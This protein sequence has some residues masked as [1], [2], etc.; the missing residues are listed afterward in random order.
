M[1]STAGPRPRASPRGWGLPQPPDWAGMRLPPT[2]RAALSAMDGGAEAV[3]LG[4]IA[5]QRTQSWRLRSMPA[6]AADSGSRVSEASTQATASPAAVMAAKVD[7]A[8]VVRPEQAGPTSSVMAPMGRPPSSRA[9]ISAMPV[10]ACSRIVRGR[11][12]SAEGIRASRE[13]SIWRR[14]AAADCNGAL[15]EEFMVG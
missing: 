10:A 7:C 1:A 5:P 11:G 15:L 13:A 3:D 9:S 12:V 14:T 4:A 6:A 2:S 8:S